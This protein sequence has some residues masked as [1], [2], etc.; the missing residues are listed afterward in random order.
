[1]SVWT[2]DTKCKYVLM[3]SLKKI[4]H[5]ELINGH[6]RWWW[7]QW[8]Q[9]QVKYSLLIN[10]CP[11]TLLRQLGINFYGMYSVILDTVMM[12]L[13][14]ENPF[15]KLRNLFPKSPFLKVEFEK[16][17]LKLMRWIIYSTDLMLTIYNFE[18][19][20]VVCMFWSTNMRIQYEDMILKQR[21]TWYGCISR[22][23]D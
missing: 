1:M 3:F 14:T 9:W 18:Y 6:D 19:I 12:S 20:F 13:C 15:L 16:L 4:A 8:Q 7:D 5:K 11:Y 21:V 22:H 10:N 23:C 17:V 2:N